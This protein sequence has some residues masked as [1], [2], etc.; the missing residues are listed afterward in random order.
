MKAWKVTLQPDVVAYVLT[1][2]RNRAV[3]IALNASVGADAW[4]WAAWSSI[5]RVRAPALDGSDITET[6]LIRNV[7]VE[8]ECGV[9]GEVVDVDTLEA[10]P[11]DDG[12]RQ[13]TVRHYRDDATPCQG[14][15]NMVLA[16][17][18]QAIIVNHER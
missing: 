6:D 14:D 10:N 9:C 2:E 17:R 4:Q 15:T 3:P 13:E 1:N 8:V 18:D 16:G 12:D 5:R 11:D 7:G